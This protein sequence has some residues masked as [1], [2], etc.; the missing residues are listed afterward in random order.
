MAC[1]GRDLGWG[2]MHVSGFVVDM[3]KKAIEGQI[4]SLEGMGRMVNLGVICM[5]VLRNQLSPCGRD[6]RERRLRSEDP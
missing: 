2:W 4:C 5:E 6:G 1:E 3:W